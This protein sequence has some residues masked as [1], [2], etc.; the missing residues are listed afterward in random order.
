MTLADWAK[1]T[2]QRGEAQQ[3]S[4]MAGHRNG[5]T[6]SKLT[7]ILTRENITHR[8]TFKLRGKEV[9]AKNLIGDSHRSRRLRETLVQDS[10]SK[11]PVAQRLDPNLKSFWRAHHRALGV[12]GGHVCVCV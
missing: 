1:D 5:H 11:V 6:I 8:H 3:A 10:D 7:K 2:S 9:A 12:R 4:A